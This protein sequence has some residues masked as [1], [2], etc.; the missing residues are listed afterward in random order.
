MPGLAMTRKMGSKGK[1]V[2][3]AIAE[4]LGLTIVQ[5]ELIDHVAEQDH[6]RSAYEYA[7]RWQPAKRN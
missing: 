5:H 4:E 2:A 3:M 6:M 7:H 1:N